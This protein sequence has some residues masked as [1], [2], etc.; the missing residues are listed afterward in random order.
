MKHFLFYILIVLS[1]TGFYDKVCAQYIQQWVN[2]YS[3]SGAYYD[4]ARKVISDKYG[5]IYVTGYIKGSGGD[6]TGY[7]YCTIKYNS[8]GVQEWLVTY[9]GPGNFDDR[10]WDMVVD[11]T[12]NVYVTGYSSFTAFPNSDSTSMC[13]I[14]Y[15][16]NGNVKWKTDYYGPMREFNFGKK[17]RLDKQGN[18]YIAGET[19]YNVN[20][21]KSY[22]V[23]K[24]NRNGIKIWDAIYGSPFP[25]NQSGLNGMVI[26]SFG[27]VYVTGYSPHKYSG[28]PSAVCTIKYD[29]SGVMKWK[30]I[31]QNSSNNGGQDVAVD[32]DLSVYVA[33][34]FGDSVGLGGS[35]FSLI[36]YNLLGELQWK[37]SYLAPNGGYNGAMA[38]ALDKSGNIIVVGNTQQ[39]STGSDITTIK[40]K[41]NGDTIWVRTYDG[42]GDDYDFAYSLVLDDNDNIYVTGYGTGLDFQD[43]YETVKYSSSGQQLWDMRYDGPAHQADEANSICLDPYG[44]IIVTGWSTGVGTSRDFCTVKYNLSTNINNHTEI[45]AKSDFLLQNYPNPF[46]PVTKINYEL[47][48]DAKVKLVIYD[49]LGREMKSLVNN[50]FKTAGRYTVEFNGTQFASGVYFYRIQ[51]EGGSSYTAVKKMVLLK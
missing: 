27:N 38:L 45:I 21:S 17:I 9:N 51:V 11:D 20:L 41:P 33:C 29:S 44:Y 12:G 31:V 14:K 47:P 2:R 34:Y 28:G 7:D 22:V 42:T 40:F 4:D 13:T 37:S 10:A 25:G 5:N 39:L 46:N 26:D 1:I 19:R 50:E 3:S 30:G 43:D 49:I 6:N 8:D 48:K 18:I 36:K 35:I 15:D 32:K 16:T 23:V 24:Y